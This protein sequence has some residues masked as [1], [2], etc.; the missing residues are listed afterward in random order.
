MSP[1]RHVATP[2]GRVLT[3][4]GERPPG[5][6]RYSSRLALALSGGGAR[7]AYQV[8]VLAGLAERLPGLEF[9]ILT[10]VSAGAINISYLAAHLGTFP[11]AV[12]KLREEWSRLTAERIYRVRFAP[13]AQAALQWMWHGVTGRRGKHGNVRGL[14]DTSPLREF[15]AQSMDLRAIDFNI[16]TGRLRAVALSATSYT[17]GRSVTFVHG[18]GDAPIWERAQRVAVREHLTIDHVMASAALPIIF[19]AV[20]LGDEYYGDGSVSHLA[21]LAPALHLGARAIVAIAPCSASQVAVVSGYPSAAEVIGLLFRAV[22]LDTL[23]ADAERLERVN[24]TLSALAP[25]VSAPDGLRPVELLMVRPS[26]ELAT[27]AAGNDMLLPPAVRLIVRAIGGEGAGASDF[28]GHLLFHPQYTSRL[29]D[30]GY[31]DVATQWP[32]IERFFEKLE[33]T[34]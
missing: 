19:P 7:A 13:L 21:P 2:L 28:L 22:F 17:T 3:E 4:P 5:T 25:G 9:P 29:A 32:E 10:G 30:L 1:I 14:V 11:S 20:R 15:L 34:E 12:T 26:R 23:E 18:A 27:L 24:H 8:G 31:E 6:W 16:S 33:R